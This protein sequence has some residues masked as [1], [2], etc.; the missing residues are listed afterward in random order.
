MATNGRLGWI[1]GSI[2]ASTTT[3]LP[4]KSVNHG[5]FAAGRLTRNESFPATA[6]LPSHL[7]VLRDPHLPLDTNVPVVIKLLDAHHANEIGFGFVALIV[8]FS[9][10]GTDRFRVW[11]QLFHPFVPVVGLG[12]AD[13]EVAKIRQVPQRGWLTVR[14]TPCNHIPLEERPPWFSTKTLMPCWSPNSESRRRPSAA[15]IICSAQFP[16]WMHSREWNGSPRIWPQ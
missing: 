15:R 4:D 16:N 10:L 8:K 9:T 5:M 1:S 14:I 7:L 2:W 6:W 12:A 11:H 13:P 3:N